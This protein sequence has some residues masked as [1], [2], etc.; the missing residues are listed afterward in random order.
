MSKHTKVKRMTTI[1]CLAVILF[2]L[3]AFLFVAGISKGWKL[4]LAFITIFWIVSGIADLVE[5][6]GKK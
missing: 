6:S 2:A 3:Y 1:V 4:A 5:C